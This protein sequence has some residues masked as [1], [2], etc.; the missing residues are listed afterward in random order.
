M[1]AN[2]QEPE[3]GGEQKTFR[4]RSAHLFRIYSLAASGISGA[5]A[6]GFLIREIQSVAAQ[7]VTIESCLY[8]GLLV[9]VFM[10]IGS[11]IYSTHDE[12]DRLVEWLSPQSYQPPR[13]V[14]LFITAFGSAAVLVLLVFTA[15][16]VHWFA[17]VY[18]LYL[19]LNARTVFYVREEIRS[20]ILD[21]KAR[22]NFNGAAS[23]K[24][25]PSRK[26]IYEHGFEVLEQYYLRDPHMLRAMGMLVIS[27]GL[28]V[29]GWL[30]RFV[31]TSWLPIAT[32]AGFILLIIGGQIPVFLW[33]QRRDRSFRELES[34]LNRESPR[35]S[36]KLQ[37]PP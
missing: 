34:K 6:I 37:A 8:I 15:R 13:D 29:L 16:N 27:G 23:E 33:R 17:T 26:A 20:A 4:D 24:L 1:N 36:E 7:P 2:S 12:L 9:S 31:T 28:L 22:L 25:S 30:S 32:Y 3:V 18:F 35:Q 19:S 10:L 11:W 14:V 21:S 5:V